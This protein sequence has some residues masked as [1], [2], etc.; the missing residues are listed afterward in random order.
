MGRKNSYDK[1]DVLIP[2]FSSIINAHKNFKILEYYYRCISTV[3]TDH[4]LLDFDLTILNSMIIFKVYTF[5]LDIYIQKQI[6]K[7]LELKG[8]N[9]RH[10]T[11]VRIYDL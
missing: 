7:L 9:Q 3:L 10:G 5:K 8:V 11:E 4:M 2:K 1:Y 6:K